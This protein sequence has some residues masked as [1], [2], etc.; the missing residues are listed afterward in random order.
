M[1]ASNRYAFGDFVLER[2]HYRVL[3]ADG[4]ALA[5]TPRLFNALLLFVDRAGEL[6]DK[7]LLMRTLWPGL[8]VEENNLSQVVS[9][10]RRSLGDDG[11]SSRYIQTVPRR[12]FVFVCPVTP[13]PEP[14]PPV[15]PA[16][17]ATPAV[18]PTSA[19]PLPA[20]DGLPVAP[21]AP[22]QPGRRRWLRTASA[23]GALGA[24]AGIGWWWAA[25]RDR[26][27]GD[28]AMALAVLPFK[29]LHLEGRDELLEIGMADSLI[30]R[31]ST[32]PGLAVRSTG[33]VLRYAGPAQ[34]PLRA[35]R[36]LGVDWIVDGTLQRRGDSLRVSA[37]L[38]RAADGTAA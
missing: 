25:Q 35:A 6:L 22:L 19:V 1:S 32:L 13:L 12:G 34:D 11:E 30:A 24:T 36:E 20:D 9:A 38:L 29:P 16:A 8:V 26:P 2:S 3:R 10:L 28:A 5:L 7:D 23:A 18:L 14:V 4:T 17:P 15:P 21:D 27:G 33:S 31:L 37:R